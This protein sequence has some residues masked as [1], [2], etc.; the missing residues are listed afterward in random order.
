MELETM[1]TNSTPGAHQRATTRKTTT[2]KPASKASAK[3]AAAAA[4][5]NE[6]RTPI[7][8][9]QYLAERALLIQV[10]AGLVARDS[11]VSTVRSLSGSR[12]RAVLGR[13]LVRYERRGATARTRLEH[14]VGT[15]RRRV[16]R[17]LRQRR[18]RLERSVQESRRRFERE[19]GSV[20][21][22]LGKR[23]EQVTKLVGNAQGL[24]PTP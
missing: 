8:Q 16:E 19:L 18:S 20:R 6:P 10:G 23:S 12:T 5:S 21:R 13:E 7:E 3:P 2:R 24:I 9:V 1:A 15:T 4:T 17:D 11:L 22:D 14:E